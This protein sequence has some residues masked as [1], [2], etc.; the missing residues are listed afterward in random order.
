MTT[1]YTPDAEKPLLDRF[2]M[3]VVT[4]LRQ[5]PRRLPA[6]WF[7]DAR[8]SMLFDAICTLDEYY[9]TRTELGILAQYAPEMAQV[10]GPQVKVIEYGSGS[11]LKTRLFLRHL[12]SPAAYMPVE[13]SQAALDA[14]VVALKRDFPDLK[15][16]PV[17]ADYTRAIEL[18]EIDARRA[19]VFFPGSTLGNFDPQEASAFLGQMHQLVGEQGGAIIGVDL[20]KDPAILHAAYNDAQGVTAQFNRNVL[21]R[22]RAEFGEQVDP[23]DF[24][25]YAFYNPLDS[26]IEM[27]LV[28]NTDVRWH[29]HEHTIEIPAGESIN[30]E[31]SYKYTPES[32]DALVTQAGFVIER[33]WTD[34]R[35][36]FGVFYI[37]ATS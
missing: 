18:P 23:S 8:G 4:G 33:M 24:D 1:S 6:K 13:I 12:S 15:I 16:S 35:A 7:Y 11:G 36:Y 28:A 29:I 10:L 19:V 21:H 17:H 30:T 20:K 37:R 26:R 5:R 31:Y 34:D 9:L 14:S 3:D 25:H 27:H 22:M 2:A 32:F